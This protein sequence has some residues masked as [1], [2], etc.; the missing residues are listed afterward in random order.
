MAIIII[1]FVV[2]DD[3]RL[4]LNATVYYAVINSDTAVNTPVYKIRASVN[5]NEN[6]IDMS[7]TLTKTLQINSLFE[8]EGVS[9]NITESAYLWMILF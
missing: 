9:N 4:A 8:F 1:V 2:S 7:I 6:P 3:F 5:E